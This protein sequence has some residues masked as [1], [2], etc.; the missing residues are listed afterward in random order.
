MLSQKLYIV[1]IGPGSKDFLTPL[2]KR[3]IENSDCLIAAKRILSL[4][5]YP[6]KEKLYFENNFHKII[7]YVKKNLKKKKIAILVSGDPGLYSFLDTIKT[8]LRKEDYEVIPGISTLQIAFAKIGASWP[9]AKI[10][11]LHG[12]RHHNLAKEIENFNKVF[13]F[14]DQKFPPNKIA[15]YLLKHGIENR[16]AVVFENISYP[17][18]K[19]VETNL[20]DLCSRKGLGLCVMIIEK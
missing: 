14:T 1:G 20:K 9:G 6:Q 11:S 2:A 17:Q 10:I 16:R 5:N 8:H 15:S 12:R 3:T 13:L 7:N 19:I 4:F 18:E